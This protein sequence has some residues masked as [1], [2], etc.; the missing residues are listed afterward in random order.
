[1]KW[2]WDTPTVSTQR[3][4]PMPQSPVIGADDAN[5]LTEALKGT[6]PKK[7]DEELAAL[8]NESDAGIKRR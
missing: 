6:Q 2:N 5:S 4:N 8:Q 1:M 3:S 7:L